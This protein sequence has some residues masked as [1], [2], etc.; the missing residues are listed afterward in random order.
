MTLS[1]SLLKRTGKMSIINYVFRMRLTKRTSSRFRTKIRKTETISTNVR[2]LK[3]KI[4]F[5]GESK[6]IGFTFT[7]RSNAWTLISRTC[8]S[9]IQWS[10][11]LIERRTLHYSYFSLVSI[12]YYFYSL[13]KCIWHEIFYLFLIIKYLSLTTLAIK[14]ARNIWKA[15]FCLWNT[16]FFAQN[17]CPGDRAAKTSRV[18]VDLCRLHSLSLFNQ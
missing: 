6:V 11:H 13:L 1:F 18:C 5:T 4:T 7:F 10:F 15:L 9:K 3:T 14:S 8:F 2:E 16:R 12:F 17:M